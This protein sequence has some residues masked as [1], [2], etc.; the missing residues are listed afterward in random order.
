MRADVERFCKNCYTCLRFKRIA[1]RTEAVPV[2]PS[3]AECWEEVMVD[4]EGPSNPPDKDG[5]RY[6]MTYICCLC[7]GIFLEGAPELNAHEC[8]RMFANCVFRSGR[9]PGLVRSDRG[10]EFR[11]ALMK[12]YQALLKV[13]NRFGTEWRPKEQGLVE[14]KHK[15]TQKFMGMLVCDIMKCLPNETGELVHVVEYMV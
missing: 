8:R 7:H 14:G 10:S 1:T 5:N 15:E 11:N 6:L 9:L 13:G 3:G 12:E 4:I 2:I